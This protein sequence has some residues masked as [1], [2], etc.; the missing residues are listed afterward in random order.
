MYNGHSTGYFPLERGTRQGDPLSAYL[1]ILKLEIMFIQIRNNDQIKGLKINDN[2]IKLSAYADD[3]YFIALD[4]PSLQQ[5]FIIC[6][7][8]EEFSSLKLNLDKC[9]ACWIGSA[10]TKLDTPIDCNWVNIEKDKILTL[11][12]F[13]SYDQSLADKNNFLNLI[14]SMRDTLNIWKYRGLTLAGR[15]QIF[16]CLAV[17]KT[18]YACT[19]LSPSKQFIDQINSLKKDFVWRGKRPKI[20]HSTLI[21][22]YKEGRYKDVDTEVKIV[23]LKIIWINKLMANDFHAWKAF[24]NFVFDKVGIRSLFHYNFKPSK[25]TS[26]KIGLLSQFYQELVSFWESVSGKQPSCISEIVG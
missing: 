9:Q 20:K 22:G 26:Q 21:G 5:V 15:I 24:P 25:N 4:V 17:S 3:T 16:K 23:A 6:N 10:K 18:L 11:G 13:N 2:I 1:F 12:I 19:M 7:T 14:T 8:F